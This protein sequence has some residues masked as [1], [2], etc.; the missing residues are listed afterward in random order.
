MDKPKP[1]VEPD[2]REACPECGSKL[3]A[4]NLMVKLCTICQRKKFYKEDQADWIR[5]KEIVRKASVRA[6]EKKRMKMEEVK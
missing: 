2:R 1:W 4:E 6:R 5:H 3:R